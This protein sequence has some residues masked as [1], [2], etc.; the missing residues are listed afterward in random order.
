M[1]GYPFQPTFKSLFL[2]GATTSTGGAEIKVTVPARCKYLNTTLSIWGTTAG[3][4][5]G[6]DVFYY[7]AGLGFAA[8]SSPTIVVLSSGFS[9]T[10]T[11]GN[12]SFL[13]NTTSSGVYL[14]QGDILGVSGSTGI[15]G[16][17]GYSFCHN[18]QEF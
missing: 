15:A 10:T 14:N 7:P 2:D 5:S 6:F 1:A 9:I 16:V 11:S 13:V 18:L 4:T 12:V 17:T 3:G 8:T